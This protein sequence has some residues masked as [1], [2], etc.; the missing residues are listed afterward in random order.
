[1]DTHD[2]KTGY[3]NLVGMHIKDCNRSVAVNTLLRLGVLFLNDGMKE[4]CS[5]C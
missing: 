1:M 2:L 5:N 4:K 3:E